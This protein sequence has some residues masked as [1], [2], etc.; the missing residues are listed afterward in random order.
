MP[1]THIL[2]QIYV[3]HTDKKECDDG[4]GGCQ[5]ICVEQVA[6]YTCRCR[7]GYTLREDE[8]TCEGLFE[9]ECRFIYLFEEK[10]ICQYT[11]YRAKI[12][13][14]AVHCLPGNFNTC[15]ILKQTIKL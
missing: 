3:I 4:N 6:G 9:F 8:H 10:P 13:K 1:P 7:S 5:H 12:I 15:I 11:P 2:M 14:D